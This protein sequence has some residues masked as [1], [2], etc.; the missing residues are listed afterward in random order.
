MNWQEILTIMVPILGML[1]WVYNRVDK[2]FDKIDQR[3]EKVDQR[4]E[5]INQRFEKVEE[6]LDS[7]NMR[8]TRLE[9]RFEERGYWESRDYHKTGTEDKK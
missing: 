7:M 3:F 4:F 2:R 5:K 8:L 1:G 6:K 9:G